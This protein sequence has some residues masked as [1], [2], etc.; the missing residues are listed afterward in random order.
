MRPVTVPLLLA[1]VATPALAAPADDVLWERLRGDGLVVLIRHALAPGTHVRFRG[2]DVTAGLRQHQGIPRPPAG[3]FKD[4]PVRR[5]SSHGGL[6][7]RVC[8]E[9]R[10]LAHVP[11]VPPEPIR[12]ATKG[13]WHSAHRRLERIA[14]HQIRS[15]ELPLTKSA[16][17]VADFKDRRYVRRWNTA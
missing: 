12:I 8:N 3:Q 10:W 16:K 15:S 7:Q 2:E 17:H 6:G 4:R 11:L 14:T 1:L 13:R 9:G 5:S